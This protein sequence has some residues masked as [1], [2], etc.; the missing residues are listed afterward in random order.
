MKNKKINSLKFK[1]YLLDYLVIFV[2]I[3]TALV[4]SYVTISLFVFE[5]SNIFYYYLILITLISSIESLLI[6][7]F[8]RINKIALSVQLSVIYLVIALTC[9]AFACIIDKDLITKP[10]FWVISLPSSFIG[11]GALLFTTFL[12]KRKEEKS[13]II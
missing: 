4:F 9:F 7:L 6:E 10:L 5:Q 2:T 3:F 13:S 11:L 12:I 1:K 8:V